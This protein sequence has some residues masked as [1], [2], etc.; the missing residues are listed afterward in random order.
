MTTAQYGHASPILRAGELQALTVE[1][2][3]DH[4]AQLPTEED[5]WLQAEVHGQSRNRPAWK[6]IQRWARL[7]ESERGV[8]V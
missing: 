4:L 2:L 5:F 7:F 1:E 3:G 6:S 8:E